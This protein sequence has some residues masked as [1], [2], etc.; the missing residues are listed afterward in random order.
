MFVEEATVPS[1][2]MAVANHPAL[3]NT[4]RSQVL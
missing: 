2:H 3:P 1:A 4:N